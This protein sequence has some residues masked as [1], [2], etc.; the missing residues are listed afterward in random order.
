MRFINQAKL[1]LPELISWRREFHRY[2]ELSAKEYETTKRIQDFLAKLDIPVET[3]HDT[4]GAVGVIKGNRPGP[5]VALR[6]DIDALPV[7][8]DNEVSYRSENSGV[9]HACGHDVHITCLLG[10]AKMLAENRHLLSGTVKLIFQPDEEV[11]GGAKRMIEKGLLTNPAVDA[12]FGLHTQPDIP[13]GQVGM[14]PGGL[15]ASTNP[16]SVHIEGEGGHGGIPQ[17]TRD[18]I[19]AAASLIQGVQSIV[20]R[21]VDPLDS[22]VITFGSIHG[23]QIGNVIPDS[24]VLQGTVRT[25]NPASRIFVLQQLRDF[26]TYT[27]SATQTKMT[28]NIGDGLPVL[29]NSPQLLSFC[30][31]ALAAIF[32][33][34]NIVDAKPSMGGEDFS[35]YQ[36]CV[37]GFFLW[38][39]TGN[40]DKGIVHSWHHPRYNVDE[41][42]L[43]FGSAAL[44]Q[45]A[46][47]YVGA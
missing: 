37:P 30:Q 47:D 7:F 15:M 16:F 21:R 10:A 3:W 5:V 22:V 13:T 12:I 39:G 27:A 17:K 44:A 32:S 33:E 4:T 19:V 35:F 40:V 9:M 11:G 46:F 23:G 20:S 8:E 29:Y 43:A 36:E 14:R 45:L 34:R 28:I 38:L 6:A 2:P 24:V 26:V 25:L 1:L 42:C 18:P 31:K 41:E